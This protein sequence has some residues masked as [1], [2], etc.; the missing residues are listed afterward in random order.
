M[1]PHSLSSVIAASFS[2]LI[3]SLVLFKG[4]SKQNVCFSLLTY[5]IAFW[6]SFPWLIYA[7]PA[8]R[9]FFIARCLYIPAALVPSLF[10]AFVLAA[11]DRPLAHIS[12]KLASLSS[13][14]F[15]L[16]LRGRVFIK[17]VQ[18]F[19]GVAAP[20]PGPLYTAFVVFFVVICGYAFV[21][22]M[23]TYAVSQGA[24]RNRLKFIF[25]SFIFAYLSGFLHFLAA[26]TQHEPIPHDLLIVF[27]VAILAY[28]ILVHH[29]MDINV[30][31][32]K[33][34][35]YSIITA[36][37]ASLYA[38]AVTLLSRLVENP[39]TSLVTF[40]A[41]IFTSFVSCMKASF[42]YAC[43]ATS[44]L[45]V[46]LGVL[47]WLKGMRQKIHK[48][49]MLFCGAVGL[50]S[51]GI[52]FMANAKSITLAYFWQQWFCYVG[53]IM[54]PILFLHFV[55]LFVGANSPRVLIGGYL[56]ALFLQIFNATG[57]FA[58]I[59]V[60][61]PFNYYTLPLKS[62]HVFTLY[63]LSL[64]VFAHILLVE[65]MLRTEGRVKNQVKFILLGTSIG[66]CGGA[67]TFLFTYRIPIF[68]YGIY[69]VPIYIITVSYAIF[70]H[71]LMDIN[72]VIRKTLLYS[73]VSTALAS[74]Y[75][76]TIT[77]LAEVLGARQ[78]SASVFSSALAAI[79]ITLLFNPLRIRTQRWID[80]HFPH[81]HLD[82]DLLQET[83]GGFAHE[84]KRPLSKIS[85]P[86]HLA[87][88]ELERVKKGEKTWEE[89]IPVVE[90]RLRFI[91]NQ[92]IEA[93]YVIEAIRELSSS[94][95]PFDPVDVRSVVDVALAA[96]KDLLE[97]HSIKVRLHLP[98]DL[99]AVSGRAKQLEIVYVNLIK[100]A[101]EAMKDLPAG[102]KRELTI[103]GQFEQNHVTIRVV[104]TGSG[105]KPEDVDIL[106][107]ARHTT[108]GHG[109]TGLGL[110]LSRQII[111]GHN[112]SIEASS[113]ESNGTT[114][115]IRLPIAS[116]TH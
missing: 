78:G 58:A 86:A 53:A 50:W 82:P 56:V 76:G 80:R 108:K 28:A 25:A 57:H 15:I 30:V 18:V 64:A 23:K 69:A 113:S 7:S 65:Q 88:M 63:F 101:A 112:G 95:L 77:V 35:L 75:V 49:W 110:Y 40:A 8:T 103:E 12:L 17:G 46:G 20:L 79:F 73:F 104:D 31:I 92:S 99:R 48:L 45:S 16:S 33:T 22:L 47:V 5:A 98:A 24:S 114:F 51:L 107:H 93:G 109:G 67:T 27:F 61:P 9:H 66:F 105:V 83:A 72:V 74:V 70:K 29:L 44:V 87:L 38:G 90:E 115:I 26:Y 85:F 60:Q 52:G 89:I 55:S 111:Q 100:N 96:N 37:M 84:M 19:N 54:I 10:L 97:K 91:V 41:T 14:L 62:F 68:P 36:G 13:L 34:L 39:S 3:S 1:S 43:I 2:F 32:R 116:K 106:F 59:R 6:T 11:L 21:L 102:K 94:A 42:T 81:E 4:R 71:Q